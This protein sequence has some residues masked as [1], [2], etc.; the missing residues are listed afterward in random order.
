MRPV[1]ARC[2]HPFQR[3]IRNGMISAFITTFF[4]THLAGAALGRKELLP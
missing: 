1:L 4:E 3:K 2:S